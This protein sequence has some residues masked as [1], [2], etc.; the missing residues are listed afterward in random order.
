MQSDPVISYATLYAFLLVLTRIAGF[1]VFVPLPGAHAGPSLARIAASIG[2]TMALFSRWPV[3][4]ASAVTPSL[5]AAW[6]LGEAALGIFAG[7]A[8]GFVSEA[9]IFGAQV[10]SVQ[11]GFAYASVIDPNMQAD[12]GVLLILAQ[13][14][15]GLLFFALGLDRQII[16]TLARSLEIWPP[17]SFSLTRPLAAEIV[18]L[19]ASIFS[20]GLRIAL[21]ITGLL[22]MVDLALAVL[23]RMHSQLQITLLAFPVKILLA[24]LLLFWTSAVFPAVLEG[25]AQRILKGVHGVLLH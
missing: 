8:I 3:I 19:A 22:V 2:C 12:S 20:V 15:G 16:A 25:Y 14:M 6:V 10:L 18:S 24:V 13:L 4:D 21:P 23:G 9:L 17:G 5:L 7:L 1:F 11:A